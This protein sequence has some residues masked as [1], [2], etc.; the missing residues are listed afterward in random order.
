MKYA[1]VAATETVGLEGGGIMEFSMVL[2]PPGAYPLAP[3]I[4]LAQQFM[5]TLDEIPGVHLR[6]NPA[7]MGDNGRVVLI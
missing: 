7:Y 1:V 6:V 5:D 2:S 4:E 3:C